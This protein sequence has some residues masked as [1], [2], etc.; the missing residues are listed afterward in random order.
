VN[1]ITRILRGIDR[2]S[3]LSA[4]AVTIAAV[5]MV[6]I[7]AYDVVMRYAFRAPTIWQYDLSYMLGGSIV[8]LGTGYVHRENRHVRVD[9]LYSLFSP[10]TQLLI[11]IVC[12]VLLFFPLIT[13][14]IISASEH[15][16]HAYAV[17]E[18]SEVGFWR[19]RMWPFRTIIPLGLSILW[20]QGLANL[21]RDIFKLTKG[22][23][24]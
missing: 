13:G 4:R 20:L 18:F 9:I 21:I 2:I 22:K 23:A 8:M 24:L 5:I 16:L 19:P 1:R 12:T 7:I 11:D 3:L 15:A 10:K 17:K 6:V 14:L